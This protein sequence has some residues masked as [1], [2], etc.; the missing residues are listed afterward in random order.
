MAKNDANIRIY[1]G[2]AG[3]VWVGEVGV[4]A[5]TGLAAPGNGWTELGWLSDTGLTLEQKADKK[6]FYAWQGGTVVAV[7]ISKAERS[8]TFECLEETAVALGLAYPGLEFTTA[9][10]VATGTVP[11]GITGIDKA[12]TLDA[13]D[14]QGNLK[15]YV[16][17]KGNVDPNSKTEHKFDA[18]TVY[19][20][21]VDVIGEFDI[22][23][24]SPG[25]VGA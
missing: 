23:T 8:F 6:K 5:P 22:I 9:T 11:A 18:L 10:G 24:N 2:D 25:V 13:E 19:Q 17:P 15:R 14:S 7:S 12:F 20:F 4:T 3:A 16:V 1:G 21:V